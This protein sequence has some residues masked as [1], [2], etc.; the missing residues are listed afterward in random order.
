MGILDKILGRGWEWYLARAE[1][2]LR[3]EDF[4]EALHNVRKAESL[5]GEGAGSEDKSRIESLRVRVMRAT[6]DHALAS[7]KAFLASKQ[8]SEAARNAIDRALRHAL[9][10]EERDAVS[11]LVEAQLQLSQPV[12]K[13]MEEVRVA[14]SGQ[15]NVLTD[16]DKWSMYVT[17]LPFAKA[18]RYDELGDAFKAAWIALQEGGVDEAIAGLEAVLKAHPGNPDVMAE[19]GRAYHGKGELAKAEKFLTKAD[20][21][22]A[23]VE[24]KI[25]R[26]QVL[27]A[28]QRFD[29]AEM[30]LQAAHDL[31]PEDSGVLAAIAQHGLLSKDYASGIDAI[32]V[33]IET[34]PED[35]SVHRLGGR[36]YLESG[37][38][39]KA[40]AC[41]EAVNRLFWKV[42]PQTKKLT[43]DQNSAAAAAGLY[44][45]RGENL[46]R[47]A[48]L[49]DAV[50]S[51][52]EGE[53]HV[54]ICLQL[55]QVYE[56]M[57]K[58]SRR[59]EMIDEAMRFMDVVYE[60][61]EGQDRV[62]MCLRYADLCEMRDGQD[63]A[64]KGKALEML[65][66][67]REIVQAEVDKG[68][69]LAAVVVEVI[70]KRIE[71]EPLP[72]P[73]ALAERQM[74][75]LKGMAEARGVDASGQKLYASAEDGVLESTEDGVSESESGE[76]E[77]KEE[78]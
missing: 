28:M 27:W 22:R 25:S 61:S 20:H 48:E 74:A 19:L 73:E 35:V 71:G 55:A 49:L 69:P 40:L 32:E 75:V 9:T 34:H 37:D 16:S 31:A 18:H 59:L 10:Q 42:D 67:A 21:G 51:L 3:D 45:K 63:A 4:G 66:E 7:A 77:S 17:H 72:S 76:D 12:D 11:S 64:M 62:N 8:N 39:D 53:T 26:V 57:G 60:A 36:L 38:D 68:N 52:T 65:N 6:Y 56:K 78:E 50:R 54:A 14:H 33:L 44:V 24:T 13:V 43:I 23:D 46:E 30:V 58:S 15:A 1:K 29:I 2:S 47:A 70:Q 41:F 5:L